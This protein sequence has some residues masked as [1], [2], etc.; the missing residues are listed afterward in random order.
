MADNLAQK[1]ITP[2]EIKEKT[3]EDQLRAE[4]T[5]VIKKK[6]LDELRILSEK[7]RKA[8]VSIKSI[9]GSTLKLLTGGTDLLKNLHD[10]LAKLIEEDA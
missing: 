9:I 1:P 6:E 5:V 4:P 10:D 8:L 3:T 7:R 2:E